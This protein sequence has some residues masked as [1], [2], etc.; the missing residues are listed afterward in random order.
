[1]LIPRLDIL[2]APQQ[3]LWPELA[4]TP[5]EFTLYGGTAI[6]LRLGHR[7]SVDFDFFSTKPFV[8]SALRDGVPCLHNSTL[9]QSAANTPAVSGERGG[10]VR[11]SYFGGL[12]PGQICV[13]E[14][15]EG[16]A[17]AVASLLDLCGMKAAV[18]TQR[19]EVKD[20]LDIHALMKL[21]GI[22]LAT[23]LSA[24]AFI[25]GDAFNPLIA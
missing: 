24:A 23:M 12:R 3:K 1:M 18:V 21:A 10:P 2:P 13:A 19:A 25:Y 17:F 20:Y 7:F 9:R 4:A 11:L 8:P 5:P 14:T 6:A 15:V 22:D 16:P